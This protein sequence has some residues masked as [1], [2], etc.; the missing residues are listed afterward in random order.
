[1]RAFLE[2]MWKRPSFQ[3]LIDEE[4]PIFGKRGARITD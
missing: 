3:K 2:R 4:M 1:V